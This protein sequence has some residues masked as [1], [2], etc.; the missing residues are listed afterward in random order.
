[1]TRSQHRTSAE[2]IR[3][4]EDVDARTRE[5]LNSDLSLLRSFV[6]IPSI[7]RDRVATE[8]AAKWLCELLSEKGFNGRILQAPGLPAVYGESPV[9]HGCPT[10]LFHGHYDV[11]PADPL[12]DWTSPPF[13]LTLQDERIYGRGCADDKGQ[14]LGMI[15]GAALAYDV[16]SSLPL[17]VK[18]LFE[19]EEEIGS[20]NLASTLKSE[21]SLL[22]SDLMVASDGT[23]HHSG[24]TTL[25]LGFKGVLC[26]EIESLKSFGDLHSSLAPCYPSAAWDL[27]AFLTAL[28]DAD[29]TCQVPGFDADI[30]IDRE[31]SR[32]IDELPA[33]DFSATELGHLRAGVT[34]Q[35]YYRNLLGRTTCNIAGLESGYRGPGFKTVLPNRAVARVDFRLLPNQKP[36]T[37]LALLREYAAA[38]GYK[39][40]QVRK[41]TAFPPSQ[42]KPS[43]RTTKLMIEALKRTDEGGIV[44]LPW[45]EGSGPDYLFHEILDIPTYWI[46][47][48]ADDCNMHGPR[49]NMRVTD[50]S[51]GISRMAKLLLQ[52]ADLRP[53]T[54]PEDAQ[55]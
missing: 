22:K 2:G 54:H 40:I 4:N 23:L 20:P 53:Q 29:G 46:P 8:A 38:T 12:T 35:N 36:D 47:S 41:A 24:R 39:D 49:E 37:I 14:L 28:R 32:L 43:L 21:K 1:M 17:N 6:A 42:T 13:E 48:A 25:I 51:G 10:V 11:Q 31:S 15:L 3:V 19:G 44:V 30:L 45:H 5:S 27:L 33:P 18:F 52:F 7:A 26:V 55:R 50:Y 34:A 9:K 16:R